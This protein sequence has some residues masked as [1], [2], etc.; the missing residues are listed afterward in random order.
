MKTCV[1][2]RA[3]LTVPFRLGI[4]FAGNN[5]P[6]PVLPDSVNI[7]APLLPRTLSATLISHGFPSP[8]LTVTH[9]SGTSNVMAAL[10]LDH[11]RLA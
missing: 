8:R 11:L 1:I 4:A 2:L 3:T 5:T 7:V 9:R 6:N 10:N